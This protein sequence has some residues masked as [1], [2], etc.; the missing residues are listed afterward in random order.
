MTRFVENPTDFSA[1]CQCQGGRCLVVRENVLFLD[2]GDEL[3]AVDNLQSKCGYVVILPDRSRSG[4]AVL[5]HTSCRR[6]TDVVYQIFDD[7]L[8]KPVSLP[9]HASSEM[10]LGELQR[11][12]ISIPYEDCRARV[13]GFEFPDDSEQ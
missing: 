2:D 5:Y 3:A 9:Q 4:T 11:Q 12:R 8:E 6:M 13:D 1:A 10:S 7:Y